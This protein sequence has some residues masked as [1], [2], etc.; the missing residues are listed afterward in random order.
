M[1]EEGERREGETPSSQIIMTLDPTPLTDRPIQ[2]D[3]SCDDQSDRPIIDRNKM[4]EESGKTD[5]R[6]SAHSSSM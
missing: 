3:N 5:H 4:E 6:L 2:G 1:E